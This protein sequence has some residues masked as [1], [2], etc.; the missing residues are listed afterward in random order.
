MIELP[1]IITIIVIVAAIVLFAFDWFPVDHVAIAAMV[2][3]ALTG[4]LTPAQAVQG[5][6]NPATITVAA[7]FVLSDVILKAG[8]INAIGP[9][10]TRL[11]RRGPKTVILGLTT[12]VGTISAFINNTPVVATFIPIISGA[13][14]RL[15]INPSKYLIPLSYGAIFGG[16]CT[17]IGTSTNLLVSGIAQEHGAEPFSMFLMAPMGLVFFAVGTLYMVFVGRKITPDKDDTDDLSQQERIQNF[18]TEVRVI[19]APDEE[20][21]TLGALFGEDGLNVDVSRIKRAGKILPSPDNQTEIKNGDVLLV[22]GNMKKIKRMIENDFLEVSG[23]LQS[24]EFPDEETLLIEIVILP[25]SDLG[26][27]KLSDVDFLE[28]YNATVLAVRQRGSQRFSD[29]K[30]ITLKPGDI[31]LLQTNRVGFKMLQRVENEFQS[32][33]LSLRELGVKKTNL[34]EMAIVGATIATVIALAS[35]G[36]LSIMIAAIAGI[37][38]LGFL[39]LLKMNDV[40]RAIDWQVI[41]LLAGALS[42]GAAMDESG[43]SSLIGNWLIEVVGQ[44]WGPVAVVSALYLTTLLL[45]EV[46]SNNASAALMAPIA[47]SISG[48][49]ELSPVPFLLAV[50]FA[51]SASFMTPIGYQTNTMVYSAGNYAFTDFTKVGAP[52]ALMF[53]LLATWLIPVFYPF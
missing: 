21:N 8:I 22:R 9:V 14:R 36:L 15:G 17:L 49:M 16:T 51:G 46:M 26:Y 41:F 31:L 7:M 40:Y 23:S 47:L 33:F 29:L 42:L 28:T 37:V 13:T 12:S 32:P 5:F 19:E 3:L 20:K 48:G 1:M 34:R 25:N 6:A 44:A 4:V 18:L 10:V 11:F 52:L 30:N 38:F 24:Q 45:T 2:V 27:K 35:T 43:I 53:W 50:A 39:G